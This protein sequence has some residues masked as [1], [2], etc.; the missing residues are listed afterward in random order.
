MERRLTMILVSLFCLVGGVMAQTQIT[1]T[2]VSQEDNEPIVGAAVRV[3]GTESGVATDINGRFSLTLPAG[4]KN[5]TISYL[6]MEP[7]EVVARNGMKILLRSSSTDLNEV[8]VTAMGI[9]REKKS[10][11]YATQ[12]I[13]A[14][15]LNQAMGTDLSSAMSGKLS[16]LNITPSSGMPG[17]SSH[18]TI[19]GAR[20]FTDNNTPLYVVDGM[21]IASTSD[22]DTY[23]S[24]TG[25]DYANRALD[26][27]PNDIESI[28][29]LKGQAA[30][31]LYGMRASNGV[32]IITTKS[33]KGLA[34]GKPHITYNTSLSFTKVSTLPDVQKE[35]AQ[36]SGGKFNPNTSLAWGPKIS[37][38]PNDATY[39]GNMDNAYTQRF[40]MH[41]GQYYSTKRAAAGLDPWTRPGV[42]DNLRDFFQTGTAW[43]NNV[44][45]TQNLGRGDYS[46]SIGNT[47][48]KGFVPE[49]GMQR[50]NV[51]LNASLKINKYFSTGF[52]GNFVASKITKQ[53]GANDGIMAAL[54]GCP[55][56]YDLKGIPSH[57]PDDPTSQVLYRPGSFNNPYWATK[58]NEF[59][60]RSQRFFGNVYLKF[61]Y[62][63]NERMKVD[64]KY[65]L[66]DDAYTTKYKDLYAYGDNSR[67][68]GE[69]DD[70][71]WTINE[72][73]S[74]FTAS[75]DW[76]IS[77]DWH[78]NVLYGN[79]IVQNK[80]SQLESYGN[81]FNF[82][83]WN[84]MNNISSYTGR[85]Y[86]YHTR[87][88]GNFGNLSIDYKN[89]LFLNVTGRND[90]VSSMPRNNRSFF[91]PSVS[92]GFIFTELEPLKNNILTYGKI[93]ASYAEVGMA[94]TYYQSY[95][96]IPTYGGGFSSGTPMQYPIN[97]VVAYRPYER[98]YD[99]NLKPQNTRSYEVGIDLAFLHGLFTLNYTYSRQNVKD[100]IF[101][102]PMAGSTGYYEFR[103]NGGSIHTNAHELTI[104]AR[105][106]N[107]RNVKWEMSLNYTKINNYVDKLAP[108][109]ESIMLGG[110]VEPQIRAG[111]GYKFP[112][113]YGISYLRNENGDIVV[114][115]NG[116]PMPGEEKVLGNV[117]PDF[118][119][120][121]N[122][123][124][125]LYKFRLSATFDWKKGG[126]MYAGTYTM[127]DYY[128]SSQRSADYRNMDQFL[129]E[130]P[131]VK[132]N[133]DGTYSPNDIYISGSDAFGYFNALNNIAESFIHSSTYLK[134]REISLSYPI[135][136][137]PWLNITASAFARNLLLYSSIKGFDP[138]ATQG[139]NN[140][141]GGF[142]R[143][144]LPGSSTFGFGLTFNF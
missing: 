106:I 85:E 96:A 139:N 56:S 58:N 105:P 7:V 61:E 74:L 75:F 24:V 113:I 50:Y 76:K 66:G 131:A 124:L 12:D 91:Y 67:G 44:S 47:T 80:T 73:N 30:S 55:P 87:T 111:I 49:T 70:N 79:E 129:F 10:L 25:S 21:P 119:M 26:I 68:S 69:I 81:G 37:E 29:V 109:V 5:I 141:A 39:G 117:S 35:Y 130:L 17:A 62:P 31:A 115:K 86:N 78:L 32:I 54:Y 128:G 16:G 104:G 132:E 134:L 92:L 135:V 20:S 120:G 43:S 123:T 97:G 15:K 90:I 122:T 28:N 138:E 108:G 1:G 71:S 42:Y 94:G 63:I 110:F 98:I 77:K 34:K 18:I 133:G 99:P 127:M 36:G 83:G 3:S 116:L 137:K 57:T 88:V 93:R 103:T 136:N 52:S 45:I 38:L 2:V 142:E 65:Q 51:K 8:V 144:S 107:T 41:E 48:Q 13:N 95:F 125:E 140:M 14:D 143:F 22:M 100:Q 9:S 89:M 53:A 6:G 23:N 33:G 126:K 46:F 114:D 121:F 112:V 101:D 27:D 4:K 19:R 40:G 72:L 118:Q 11:G 60:E 84:S 59:S 102:V 64:A 82:A